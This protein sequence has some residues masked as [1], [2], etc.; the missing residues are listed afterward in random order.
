MLKGIEKRSSS[1]SL[2]QGCATCDS[3]AACGPR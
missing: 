1:F 3:T 2:G